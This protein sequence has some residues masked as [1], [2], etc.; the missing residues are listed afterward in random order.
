MG[1]YPSIHPSTYRALLTIDSTYKATPHVTGL[2][3]YLIAAE[4]LSG[5]EQVKARLKELAVNGVLGGLTADSPNLLAF[6]GAE[7]S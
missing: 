2:A 3:A 6:N 5:V 1:E 7:S 4:G